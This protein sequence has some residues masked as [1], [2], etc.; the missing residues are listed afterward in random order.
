MVKLAVGVRHRNGTQRLC[1]GVL[2][3]RPGPGHGGVQGGRE[4]C[5]AALQRRPSERGRGQG[6]PPRPRLC[7]GLVE[8]RGFGR[9]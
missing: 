2:K 3:S 4:R 8:V 7:N 1:D 6:L 9:P 5:L